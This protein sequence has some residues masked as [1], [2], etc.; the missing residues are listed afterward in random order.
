MKKQKKCIES[1]IA[2]FNE[3]LARAYTITSNEEDAKDAM[4]ELAVVALRLD[5]SNIQI[6]NPKAY[7]YRCVRN[8]AVDSIR[9]NREIP[10]DEPFIKQYQNENDES[11]ERAEEVLNLERYIESCSDEMKEA[12]IRHYLEGETMVNIAKDMGIPVATLRKR[13]QRMKD[14]IPRNAFYLLLLLYDI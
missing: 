11:F 8:I 9:R 2:H 13:L 10:S 3:F 12:F 4:Q 14:R 6:Q 1:Y 5:K 7:L